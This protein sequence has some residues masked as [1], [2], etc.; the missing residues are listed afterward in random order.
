MRDDE[1]N[2]FQL[3]TADSETRLGLTVTE[4]IDLD[5]LFTKDITSSGSFYIS[6]GI[7]ATTFGKVL[8]VLPIPAL[9]IDD[10]YNIAVSNQACRKISV[11]YEHIQG[12]PFTSLFATQSDAA[13]AYATI[14]EVFGSR[15]PRVM[16]AVVEIERNRIWGRITLRPIRIA[17]TRLILALIEDL[18]HEKKQSLHDKKRKLELEKLVKERTSKLERTAEQLHR[19]IVERAQV[20]EKLT[21]SKETIEGLLNATSDMAFLLGADG[22]FLAANEPVGKHFRTP[23]SELLGRSLFELAPTGLAGVE[24][25]RFLEVIDSAQPLRFEAEQLGRFY[26][27]NFFPVVDSEGAVSAV[28]VYIRDV[29]AEKKTNELLMQSARIKA[30]G[31]M[32]SGV[33]HNFNNIL[34]IVMN[35]A[36]ETLADL[37]ADNASEAKSKIKRIIK[38]ASAGADTV[39][40]LQDFAHARTDEAAVSGK[41]FDLSSTVEQTIEILKPYWKTRPE[42]RGI[43]ISLHQNLTN[44]CLVRGK[45]NEMFEV[46]VNLI[47]NAVEALPRGGEITVLT[48]IDDD[49]AYLRIQDNGVGI[50]EPNLDRIFEPFWSDKGVDGIGM[51]LAS[52]YG[53]IKRHKGTIF[54]E[55]EPGKGTVFTVKLPLEKISSE[56][57]SIPKVHSTELTCRVLVIDDSEDSVWVLRNGLTRGGLEVLSALSGHKGIEIFKEESVDVVICDLGMPE[58]NG[59]D[60]GRSLKNIRLER[61]LQKSPFILLTGWGGL[62]GEKDKLL[63]SGVDRIVEK[64]FLVQNLIEIVKELLQLQGS[65]QSEPT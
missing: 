22:T 55:S 24:K 8:Q 62:L 61:G 12:R 51:G 56:K 13:S 40:R 28:A 29:T 15:K 32:A 42:R 38:S 26:N 34:Q 58:L 43:K 45:E 46:G 35:A 10:S 21:R 1:H 49:H 19:E 7:W 60:V 23:V 11:A 65:V 41:V 17:G 5:A 30:V 20:Q 33:A 39:R 6:G 18:T 64:P 50:A 54:A 9:L 36:Y 47:K 27:S 14:D 4:T 37:E 59:W 16:E 57:R 44:G 31:D 2:D 3:L 25:S 48:C 52:S 53:I 63:E